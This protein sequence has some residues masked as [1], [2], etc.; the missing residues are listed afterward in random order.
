MIRPKVLLLERIAASRDA[1]R[2]LLESENYEV[3][4]SRTIDEGLSEIYEQQDFDVL[5]TNLRTQRAGD[6]PKLIA[7]I[8]AF[9]PECLLV[10]VSDSLNARQARLA[11]RL[12]ADL[13]VRPAHIKQ[14]AGFL[15]ARVVRLSPL[16]ARTP[17]KS[18]VQ[19]IGG[20]R[21]VPLHDAAR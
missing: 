2:T 8:R 21:K 14:I 4:S 9:Q 20:R 3:V 17:N 18:V 13:V 10:A 12:Q 16:Q 5:I 7:A 1:M 6:H 15:S 11:I 19:P